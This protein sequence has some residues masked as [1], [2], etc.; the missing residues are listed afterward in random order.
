MKIHREYK[1]ISLRNPVVTLGIFDG[2]HLG[3]RKLLSHLVSR[4]G[5]VN[6][7]SVVITF[8]P[9][10]RMVLDKDPGNLS[11]LSTMDEKILLLEKCGIGHLI[12][13]EFSKEFSMMQACEFVEDV[14]VK[15]IGTRQ[16][17]VGHDHH[18]GHQGEG[19]FNT[20]KDC[21]LSMGFDVE[22]VRGLKASGEAISSSLIRNALITGNLS[23]ANE[24]LGYDY[25]L[26][27]LVVEGKKIG[28]EIGFPTANIK[29]SDSHKLI[30]GNGV[31]A[32]DTWIGEIK[33]AGMLSVGYNPTINKTKGARSIEVNIFSFEEDIYGKEIEIV[34]RYRLRD[35]K[36]FSNTKELSDQMKLDKENALRLLA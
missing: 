1:G 19:N 36:K 3:H 26:R 13:I 30:P 9:H 21:A 16:L 23:A 34:F 22:Q 24:W 6:G 32:V 10:P 8:H 5:E 29:P 14:L 33:Y 31:Y 15:S 17:I 28:R 18:F 20:I 7:E 11:F 12:I 4:A 25:F 27:G 2:V 35:E